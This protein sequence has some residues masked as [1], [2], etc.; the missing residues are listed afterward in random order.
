LCG[1]RRRARSS[2]ACSLRAAP[3]RILRTAIGADAPDVAARK[4]QLLG[5]KG[6]GRCMCSASRAALLPCPPRRSS[7]SPVPHATRALD[8]IGD[9]FRSA[10]NAPAT[11]RCC[12]RWARDPASRSKRCRRSSMREPRL[13]LVGA[14]GAEARRTRARR[15]AAR[16][17]LQHQRRVEHGNRL[18]ASWASP[19]PTY[20]P[21]QPAAAHG[22]YAVRVHGLHGADGKPH[23]GVASLGVRPTIGSSGKAVLE[24]HLFDFDGEL[25]RGT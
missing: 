7:S 21:A 11:L 19:P 8:L 22:I 17:A 20:S 23:D 12:A 5:A 10:P 24:V 6:I 16:P 13:E 15:G 25:Y 1:R 2:R 18:A 9:D 3:A 14:R 4:A